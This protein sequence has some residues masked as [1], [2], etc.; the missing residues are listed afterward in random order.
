MDY[1][2]Q[3]FIRW[4]LKEAKKGCPKANSFIKTEWFDKLYKYLNPPKNYRK[5]AKQG[6]HIVPSETDN[7]ASFVLEESYLTEC[8]L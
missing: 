1:L 2:I 6:K 8:G 4:N 7:S 3:R 5:Y